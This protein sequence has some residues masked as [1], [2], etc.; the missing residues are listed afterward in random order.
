MNVRDIILNQPDF[1]ADLDF[2]VNE[3]FGAFGG[4]E[5]MARKGT[6]FR[7]ESKFWTF[8]GEI[9]KTS[10][11]LYPQTKVYDEMLPPRADLADVSPLNVKALALEPDIALTALGTE[12]IDGHRCTKIEVV[13]KNKPEKVYLYSAQDLLGLAIVIRV[14]A[15]KRSTIQRLHNVSLEV[16]DSLVRVPNDFKPIEHDKWTKLVSAKLTYKGNP[17]KDYGVFRAPGGELFIWVNDAYY[18]WEYLYRPRQKTVEI[19]FQGLLVNSS[20]TYIWQTKETEA[21]SLTDYRRLKGSIIDAHLV[22]K[23][24]GI[25]FRS[26]SYEQDKS[27]IEISW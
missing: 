6:R 9:G 20:G 23:S 24:N 16:P 11:R 15:P 7:E 22:V 10:V 18:P 27:M 13:T 14:I 19:A 17:S 25:I 26:G 3:G 4:A 21:F 1:V 8:V 2:F 12:Q 5:R